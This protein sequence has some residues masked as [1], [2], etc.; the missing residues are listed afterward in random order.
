ML[1]IKDMQVAIE[2][3]MEAIRYLHLESPESAINDL[4]RKAEAVI[5]S[6]QA[7]IERLRAALKVFSGNKERMVPTLYAESC[8][9]CGFNGKAVDAHVEQALEG[10][11]I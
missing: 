8:P 10:A 9:V 11:K 7:E 6:Q 5:G 3:L 4:E 2:A 1:E